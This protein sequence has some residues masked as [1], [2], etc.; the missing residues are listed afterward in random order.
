VPLEKLT[1]AWVPAPRL[2]GYTIGAFLLACGLLLLA[3]RWARQAA[4]WL[5]I[6]L[7]VTVIV[8]YLPLLG[9]AHGTDE[10]V[11]AID[12]IFD[13]LLFAG[14]ALIVGEALGRM[15][16]GDGNGPRSS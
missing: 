10:V 16:M 13:T 12:Y 14:T 5:G 11:E 4:A 2:W 15:Q 9:P 8:I 1:P 6:A 3:N 7:T